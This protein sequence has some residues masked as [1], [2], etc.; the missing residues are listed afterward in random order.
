MSHDL[1]F[2]PFSLPSI[3]DEEVREVIAALE[4]GWL[5]SGPRTRQFEADFARYTQ[6]PF[7][8]AV[9]SCTA[10]LHLALSCLDLQPGDE[11]I[12]TPLT[13]CATVNTIL[14]A[15]GV[16]ILADI[17][18]DLNID[19]AA[20]RAAITPRTR[21]IVPVH[22][23][24]LPCLMDEIWTVAKEAGLAVIEDAAHAA[25]ATYRGT[26][27]GA[28]RSTAV[29]FSFYATKNLCTGEGGMVTT[30]SR[31]LADR[32]RT[33]CL[34]GISRDAW[35]RYA[36]EG[37]WYYEV[38]E[39]GFKYNMSDLMAALGIH[40]LKKL[41]AMNASRQAIVRRYTAAFSE[42]AELEC[43]PDRSDSGHAWHLY[44]LRLHLDRLSVD[45]GRICE[46][47]R[48]RGVGSSVHFI[49]IPL[50]PY[51][52]ETLELRDPCNRAL[53]DY[54]RLLS[55]P[56][57]PQMDEESVRR[58]IAAV[59]DVICAYRKPGSFS[60]APQPALCV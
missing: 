4:S 60:F 20:I 37:N 56:L 26:P 51:Y 35:N 36:K 38:V 3:G 34:H 11:V 24:G 30:G 44:V 42:F 47:L 2:V 19:P 9:N 55:L 29:A 43:P 31:A 33:L 58:V 18:A 41:D 54:P 10:G 17:G 28:G 48:A 5:T 57:Y 12:T 13:F 16:P 14:Q 32:M 25:G 53:A 59:A 45:R 6:S 22:F 49:P 39:R 46:E 8:L 52:R 27:V 1:P 21:A 50:H 15:G 23:G 7:A 40:Q